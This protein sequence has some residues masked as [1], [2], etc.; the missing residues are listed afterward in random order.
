MQSTTAGGLYG[1]QGTGGGGSS[2]GVGT[3]AIP[4][5]DIT[6]WKR[7]FFSLWTSADTLSSTNKL[8]FRMQFG[9]D[10]S[11]T[12]QPKLLFFFGTNSDGSTNISQNSN[13]GQSAPTSAIS[14]GSSTTGSALW[15]S[16]FSGTSGRFSMI[17]WRGFNSTA[18]VPTVV[19]NIERSHDASGNDTDAYWTIV[20][21]GSG[22]LNMQQSIFK[23]G[24]GGAGVL[25]VNSIAAIKTLPAVNAQSLNNSI[26]VFPVF[27]AV[28]KI[29]NPMIGI[30]GMKGG[31]TGE[32][33][34]INA[35]FY[36]TTHPYFMSKVGNSSSGG[37]GSFGP[38]P[39]GTCG[40]GIR[41][42]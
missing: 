12:F 18:A 22:T 36:G 26:C 2:N 17:L 29:D 7:V 11:S 10:T 21:C 20:Y 3:G 4:G 42:E 13:W 1:F 14:Q 23:N 32:G 39:A 16:N 15:E 41:W 33:G 40:C 5:G 34:I 27:P 25:E 8:F 28:G 31:D 24:T 37:P 38:S 19:L 35:T 30:I 6:K 9:C